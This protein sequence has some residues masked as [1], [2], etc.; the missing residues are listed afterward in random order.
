MTTIPKCLPGQQHFPIPFLMVRSCFLFENLF[1][2]MKYNKK[3]QN[4]NVF[5]EFIHVYG[6]TKVNRRMWICVRMLMELWQKTSKTRICPKCQNKFTLSA[7]TYTYIDY[8]R[9]FMNIGWKSFLPYS[10][11]IETQ[12]TRCCSSIK[13]DCLEIDRKVIK[14]MG[15]FKL[16][17][18]RNSTYVLGIVITAF[19]VDRTVE[20]GAESAW[21]AANKNVSISK[22]ISISLRLLLYFVWKLTVI[23]CFSLYMLKQKSSTCSNTISWPSKNASLDFKNEPAIEW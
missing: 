15:L 13:F 16:L 7:I 17:F 12:L 10:T 5:K 18:A 21:K 8:I 3:N 23:R 2:S 22:T 11:R 4:R 6:I 1:K 14:K 20:I 9:K 19:V